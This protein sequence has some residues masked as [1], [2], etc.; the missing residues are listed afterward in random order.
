VYARGESESRGSARSIAAF[1]IGAALAAS[2]PCLTQF[3]GH[4]RA[5]G[6]TVANTRIEALRQSLLGLATTLSPDDLAPTLRI[7][8]AL[9]HSEV[10]LAT[11]GAV[12]AF[13]PFGHGNPE[14]VFLVRGAR[15]IDARRVGADE[16]H[17]M[18]RVALTNGARVRCI[19][20]SHGPRERELLAAHTVDLAATLQRDEW[21][22]DTR[23]QLR[24]RDF[25]PTQ[26]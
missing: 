5:A 14:P 6:F 3:G 12:A 23:L 25:R 20:F 8:A 4:P 24:V 21:Q 2:A 7:D 19:A 22:G 17:L 1:D 13:G 16:A 9:E 15:V 26:A 11:C 10:S 18:F